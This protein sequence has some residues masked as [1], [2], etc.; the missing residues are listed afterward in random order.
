MIPTQ[1]ERVVV[2]GAASVDS[3][4]PLDCYALTFDVVVVVAHGVLMVLLKQ[5]VLRIVSVQQMVM[6]PQLLFLEV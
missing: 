3:L 1:L 5:Q 4:P 6:P 2:V